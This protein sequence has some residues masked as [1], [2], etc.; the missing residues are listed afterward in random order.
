MEVLDIIS[1]YISLKPKHV[2]DR[3]GHDIAYKMKNTKIRVERTPF[4]DDIKEIVEWYRS[5]EGWWEAP[6]NDLYF[7]ND[8]EWKISLK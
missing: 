4:E 3:L 5:N 7:I 8:E 2:D 6:I 1:I